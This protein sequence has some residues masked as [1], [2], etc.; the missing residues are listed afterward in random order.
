VEDAMQKQCK[1]DDDSEY[2]LTA[3]CSAFTVDIEKE[4]VAVH[5]FIVTSIGPSLLSLNLL[6]H[7][8]TEH[9]QV[10]EEQLWKLW[11]LVFSPVQG[12]ELTI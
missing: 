11:R 7:H 2:Q 8:P 9:A 12:I 5:D 1:H 3:D 6:I 4:I 10:Q